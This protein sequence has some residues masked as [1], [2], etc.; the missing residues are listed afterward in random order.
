MHDVNLHSSN[1]SN[2]I[3]TRRSPREEILYN[4]QEHGH[5]LCYKFRKRCIKHCLEE[6]G[7]VI[8]VVVDTEGEGVLGGEELYK[9]ECKNNN[10]N[11]NVSV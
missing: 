3:I 11:D 8:H 5:I 1:H 10:N 2:W 4:S 6:E 7:G 9:T